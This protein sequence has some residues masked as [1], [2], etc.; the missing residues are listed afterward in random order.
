MLESLNDAKDE[1]LAAVSHRLRTPLT[2]VVGFSE[3]LK[4]SQIGLTEVDRRELLSTIA[5]QAI[6]LGH[7]FDNL[8]TV[9]RDTNRAMFSPS[10]VSVTTEVHA[11]L[12][13]VE[14]AR[15]AKVRVVAADLDVVAAGDPG[16]VRQILRNLVANATDFGDQVE[17][18]VINENHFARIVVRDNGPG[19]PP[20]RAGSMFDLYGH[21]S[22]DRGQPKSMGVGLFVSLR[23]ARRMSGNITYRRSDPWT[24]FELSLPA[25]P[26]AILVDASHRVAT[27][28]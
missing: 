14:P 26:A 28:R 2:A 4:D 10:R 16:L 20:E 11:V 5:V 7:L 23:L 17:L 6:E 27:V 22:H 13:T 21:W 8:L 24:V 19:V 9:T 12:D 3:V 25:I 15:R 18:S 1:F